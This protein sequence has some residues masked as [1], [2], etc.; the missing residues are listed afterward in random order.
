MK[1]ILSIL[2][3]SALL[4]G[5]CRNDSSRV[6]TRIPADKQRE[7]TAMTVELSKAYEHSGYSPGYISETVK[8]QVLMIYGETVVIIPTPSNQ[9]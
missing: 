9:P 3:L 2:C 8:Q 6:I 4:T 1:S 7:A 5:C